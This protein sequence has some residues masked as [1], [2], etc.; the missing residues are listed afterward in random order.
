VLTNNG[1]KPATVQTTATVHL[2]RVNDAPAITKIELNCEAS[3]PEVDEAAFQEYAAAAKIGCPISKAL[4]AVDIE[5]T[6]T[7][8]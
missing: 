6:A 1:F 3:V 8:R 5:L 7:L 4:A 2:G